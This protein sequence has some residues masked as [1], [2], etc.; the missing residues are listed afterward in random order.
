MSDMAPMMA[1][2]F[3]VV[4]Y[5]IP[6]MVAVERGHRNTVAICVLNVLLGWTLLG[7]VV[8]LVWAFT[9][10]SEQ[11]D[12]SVTAN[13][14][15]ATVNDVGLLADMFERGLLTRDEFDEMKRRALRGGRV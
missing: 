4:L 1:L 7:W 5:F 12:V 11:A 15:M 3:A 9:S 8:A 2:M 13:T 10:N 6:A 14:D